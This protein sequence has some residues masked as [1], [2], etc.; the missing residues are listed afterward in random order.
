MFVYSA[1]S[2]GRRG[3]PDRQVLGA[4]LGDP[5]AVARELARTAPLVQTGLVTVQASGAVSVDR[6]LVRRLAGA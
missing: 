3:V 5:V 6:D 4:L 1:I 2:V